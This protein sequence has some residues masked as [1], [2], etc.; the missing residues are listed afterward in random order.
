MTKY[1]FSDL[2]IA[3]YDKSPDQNRLDQV[4]EAIRRMDPR[5]EFVRVGLVPSAADVFRRCGFLLIEASAPDASKMIDSSIGASCIPL[6]GLNQS[7]DVRYPDEWQWRDAQDAVERYKSFRSAPEVYYALLA[8]CKRLS[9]ILSCGFDY[10]TIR[11]ALQGNREPTLGVPLKMAGVLDAF[12]E[13]CFGVECDL[14]LVNPDNWERFIDEE[15]PDLLLVESAWYGNGGKWQYLVGTYP[16][17]TRD[18]LREM[19]AGFRNAGIPTA[20]WNKED[21]PH[22]NQFIEA[23]ALFDFVFTTDENC[24]PS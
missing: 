3:I 20:F 14:T 11:T 5:V 16:G 19:I 12:S 15:R 23:A 6:I 4:V 18:K 24:I 8:S 10:S 2:T 17:S 13:T 7:L 22:F 1:P 9:R 21:P